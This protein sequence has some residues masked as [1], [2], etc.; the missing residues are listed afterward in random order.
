MDET[1]TCKFEVTD[2]F[3]L[4]DRGGFVVGQFREGTARVGDSVPLPDASAAWTIRG[5]EFLDN[6]AERKHSNALLFEEH[7]KLSDVKAAFPIGSFVEIFGRSRE[8]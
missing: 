2:H 8:G 3:E 4:S 1:P 7:P 6:I 5:I